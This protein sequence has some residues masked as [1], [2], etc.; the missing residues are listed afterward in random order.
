MSMMNLKQATA[1]L[2]AELHG[3][4]AVA[5]AA[6]STDTRQIRAGDLFIA[7]QGPNFD[8]HDYVEAAR[9]QGA[10]AAIVSRL[11]PSDLPQIL[12]DDTRLALGRLAAAWRA[13][14]EG[15]VIGLTGSNGK[16]TVKEMLASILSQKGNVLATEG[17]LNN[18][19]GAPLMLL[20][21]KPGEHDY[22]VIEMG[23]NHP[24]EIAYLAS[25]VQPDVALIT[26]AGL[27]HLEGFGGTTEHV[28]RAK[29]EIW[30]GLREHGTAVINL[31]DAYADYWREL[32]VDHQSLGFGLLPSADVRLGEGGVKLEMSGA[33]Y[34]SCFSIQSADGA[35]DIAMSLMG[36]HNV[37][38]ALAATATAMAAG[39]GLA[40]VK[41]G[42]EGMRPVQGRLQPKRAASG[43]WILDDSYNANPHSLKAAIEVL[44]QVEQPKILVLG[45]MGELGE[46]ADELHRQSGEQAAKAGIDLFLCSGDFCKQ[47][48][49]GF[50]EGAVWCE[51]RDLLLARLRDYLAQEK[52]KD[53]V[54]LVKG[55]RSARMD[56]VVDALVAKEAQVC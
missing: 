14:F 51:S 11:T 26:N 48:A 38:N 56:L 23:A 52:Y 47:A 29:G 8:G 49:A 22:A 53:A 9:E 41:A 19:I 54:V 46:A 44:S 30:Q 34:R 20:R 15:K 5:F 18:D 37:V 17:N 6:V 24:G 25:L 4:G 16:T 55:S 50:A 7:L 39:A 3:E 36:R 45:D 33:S 27:A 10:V 12:V 35:V 40:E 2:N 21:L 28:A 31:D 43:Q 32:V 1:F 13:Q 42:L